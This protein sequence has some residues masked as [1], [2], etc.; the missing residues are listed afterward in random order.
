MK[1]IACYNMKGGV[2]K[3]TTAVNL[4]HAASARGLRTLLWDLDSQAAATYLLGAAAVHDAKVKKLVKDKK[5]LDAFAVPT[6][7]PGL[8]VIPAGFGYRHLDQDLGDGKKAAKRL[9]GALASAS[10][11]C[12]LFFLDC[13]PSISVLSESVF[14]AADCV[15]VPVVPSVLPRETFERVRGHIAANVEHPPRVIGFW[16]MVDRRR[17]LHKTMILRAL[18][19]DSPFLET[20]IPARS[21][22]ERMG[23]EARPVAAFSPRG[24]AARAYGALL[25]EVLARLDRD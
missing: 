17:S 13:P 9:R 21:E 23:V 25:N 14:R 10:G 18:G 4:A 8:S 12:D 5:N 15:L 6:A 1:I 22:I 19:E 20:A 3:T 2:G 7:W 11:A 24:E 16:S